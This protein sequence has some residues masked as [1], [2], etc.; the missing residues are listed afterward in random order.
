MATKVFISFR[1]SDVKEIK[2]F[3]HDLN[4]KAKTVDGKKVIDIV[5]ASIIVSNAYVE[6]INFGAKELK[7]NIPNPS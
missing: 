3:I 7:I 1:F 2:D 5:E 6:G 4:E